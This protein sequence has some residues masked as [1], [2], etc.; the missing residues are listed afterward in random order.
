MLVYISWN[1]NYPIGPVFEAAYSALEKD[2]AKRKS[3]NIY[4]NAIRRHDALNE[5]IDVLIFLNPKVKIP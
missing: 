3:T 4:K 1:G 2:L 5:A